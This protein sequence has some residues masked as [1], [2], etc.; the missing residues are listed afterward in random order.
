MTSIADYDRWDTITF[1]QN[2]KHIIREAVKEV[3]TNNHV[4]NIN[5]GTITISGEKSGLKLYQH[6]QDAIYNLTEKI[7]N[8]NKYPFAGLL[9][10]PTGGGKT[11][12]AAHWLCTN[13][14]DKGKKILWIAHR[15]ELLQQAMATFHQRLA[16]ND[17]FKNRKSFN[18]RI[19]SGIH[20]RPVH[21]K[22]TDDLVIASKDSINAGFEY[23]YTNWI[24]GKSNE[25]FLV[26][27]EAHHAIAKTYRKIIEEL[28]KRGKFRMLG[29]TATPFRTAQDEKGLIFKLFEDKIV[30]EI[31]LRRLIALGILS[32]PIF[33]EV[34][35]DFD[36][37][38]VLSESEM[39]N[40][41]H[42]DIDSIGKQAAKTIAE[43]DQ[44]NWCIVN[45]YLKNKNKYKQT[46]VFALNQ[47][48]AIALNKLFQVNGIKSDYVLSSI[49]D[50]TTGVTISSEEN[51]NKIELFRK[52]ELQV[53]INVNILT[54]GVDVPK[55]Q[56]V[57]LAR[58]TISTILMTQMIGRGLRGE[59][60]GGTKEAFIVS[61]IDDWKDKVAWVN[62]I[63]QI[64]DENIFDDSSHQ[65]RKVIIK[66]LS[67]KLL[68]QFAIT[69]NDQIDNKKRE[70][71]QNLNFIERIPLGFYHFTLL[72]LPNTEKS[73]LYEKYCDVFVY[74]NL[75]Q[76]YEDFINALPNI[77]KNYKTAEFLTEDELDRFA[78][79]VDQDF[80]YG[81]EKYPGFEIQD[82]KDI[83]QY[84]TQYD[85]EPKFI[86]L[87]DR[88]KFDLGKIAQRIVDKNMRIKEKNDFIN[89]LW[90]ISQSELQLFFGCENKKYFL[91]E[92][93][94]AVLRI[95]FPECFSNTRNTPLD[96]K[97]LRKLSE[98]SM[99]RIMEV[100]PG[101]WKILSDQ[102]YNKAK[103]KD[104]FYHSAMSNYKSKNKLD[105]QID[106]ITPMKDGGLTIPENLRLLT[107]KENGSRKLR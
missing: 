48:N 42:F 67:I 81:C 59:K 60:A 8:T 96:T 105:F 27:D 65:S 89:N 69:I 41:A 85:V 94:L 52:G 47:D 61:F 20:D 13:V 43:N 51:R 1:R 92:V 53:L 21:I 75:K 5:A 2:G 45:R 101:Y 38:R 22:E 103:D 98:L 84:F 40:L 36:M 57:F 15:H 70:V 6:Q 37:T 91:N 99:G 35:T 68:E 25:V 30:Y 62:P 23:L 63:E 4:E 86:K 24:K 28:K 93:N 71:L 29:L 44:R 11:L 79:R 90:D 102:V 97:E 55:V 32:E 34:S 95:T 106:Y 49:R 58:P 50:I 82:I 54:E 18:Y 72:P 7:T 78:E 64:P 88:E 31:A 80:F 3:G 73:K 77:V 46:I 66:L 74:D 19:I 76:S 26:I 16:Y 107:R 12:T 10:L 9:V 33:E 39:D 56:S 17:I 83:L 100:N 87:V 104:G 14:L